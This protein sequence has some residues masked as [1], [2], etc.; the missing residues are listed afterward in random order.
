MIVYLTIAALL[1]A[2][3]RLRRLRYARACGRSG[4][5]APERLPPGV[6]LR[7]ANQNPSLAGGKRTTIYRCQN[8]LFGTDFD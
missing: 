7:A 6:V 8:R 4:A 2:K 3:S 1:R 5:E